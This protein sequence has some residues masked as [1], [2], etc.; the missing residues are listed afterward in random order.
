VRRPD[1]LTSLI[2]VPSSAVG[3]ASFVEDRNL[4]GTDVR[5]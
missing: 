2:A 3:M 1:D 4:L 5:G